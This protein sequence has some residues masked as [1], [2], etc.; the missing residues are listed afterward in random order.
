MQITIPIFNS[1]LEVEYTGYKGDKGNYFDPP[2]EDEIEVSKV[3]CEGKNITDI[4][5]L[6]IIAD[7]VYNEIKKLQ[8]A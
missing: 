3:I 6:E 1:P 5:D 8:T 7:E 4:L 2:T